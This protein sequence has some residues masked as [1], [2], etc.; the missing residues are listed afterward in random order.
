M[1]Q[2]QNRR[3]NKNTIM[4]QR[5]RLLSLK[6][7]HVVLD[8]AT[9]LPHLNLA[10]YHLLVETEMALAGEQTILQIDP[11]NGRVLCARPDADF[12]VWG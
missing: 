11:L 8:P 10:V 5:R 3:R 2:P 12:I 1:V 7:M 9:L 6:R 4:H